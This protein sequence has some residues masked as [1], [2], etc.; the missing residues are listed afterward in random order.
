[1]QNIKRV[2]TMLK[3]SFTMPI[4]GVYSL[5]KSRILEKGQ[6]KGALQSLCCHQLLLKDL[7]RIKRMARI[8]KFL[9]FL[10]R[11]TS[12]HWVLVTFFITGS[13]WWFSLILTYFGDSLGLINYVVKDNTITNKNLS[14]MGYI[15]TFALLSLVFT[16]T[17]I[18][19]YKETHDE[20]KNSALTYFN[21][22]SLLNTFLNSV[23][24]VCAQKYNTQIKKIIDI[25]TNNTEP[26]IV[27][28]EPCLQLQHTILEL[29]NCVAYMLSEKGRKFSPS[30][31]Y[32]SIAYNFP[33][34]NKD[35]WQWADI[36]NEK[37][38]SIDKLLS[39]NTTFS[40]ALNYTTEQNPIVFFN[41]KQEASLQQHYVPDDVD[42]RDSNHNLKGS[43]VC[44]RI[45]IKKYDTTYI[46]AILSI[47]SYDRQFVDVSAF[48]P[49]EEIDQE[50]SNIEGN[51]SRVPILEFTKRI[52][53][54]LCN[55]YIQFLRNQW[56]KCHSSITN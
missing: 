38:L 39:E 52:Q 19:K 12:K 26:P 7:R 24:N 47:F 35:V 20:E 40:Y 44:C 33:L 53:I 3:K 51:M 13:S 11:I 56:D 31:L 45:N 2:I 41:S 4:T 36:P 15:A 14:V 55:Y 17:L 8:K 42:N 30:D 10:C 34:E 37:G 32:V 5:C 43:I 46:T 48:Q 22:Y 23:N 6:L 16:I 54:E 25:K 49:K 29:K 50:I 27:Y 9:D 28:S 1:M 18:N 21:W